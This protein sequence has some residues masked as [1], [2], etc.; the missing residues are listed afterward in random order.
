MTVNCHSYSST[1]LTAFHP[2]MNTRCT[3]TAMKVCIHRIIDSFIMS[4][5]AFKYNVY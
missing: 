2:S 3:W 1:H 5:R 4:L